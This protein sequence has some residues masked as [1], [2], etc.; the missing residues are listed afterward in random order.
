MLVFTIAGGQTFTAPLRGTKASDCECLG[1]R[2]QA[3]RTAA[4]TSKAQPIQTKHY[5]ST[6]AVFKDTFIIDK[7]RPQP[8]SMLLQQ[9]GTCVPSQLLMVQLLL[10]ILWVD[11]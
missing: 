8:P 5:A 9:G 2:V 1:L 6:F 7:I 11:C 3:A 4:L 10:N